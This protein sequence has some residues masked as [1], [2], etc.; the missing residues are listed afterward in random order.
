MEESQAPA[1]DIFAKSAGP[2]EESE[3]HWYSPFS[4]PSLLRIDPLRAGQSP[5][6]A[7]EVGPP[8][9]LPEGF[10]P[11][12]ADQD[13]LGPADDGRSGAAGFVLPSPNAEEAGRESPSDDEATNVEALLTLPAGFWAEGG[14][15][16]SGEELRLDPQAPLPAERLVDGPGDP[17]MVPV[18]APPIVLTP[19]LDQPSTSPE[20]VHPL[21]A[22]P[23]AWPATAADGPRRWRPAPRQRV[24]AL[25][26]G[27]AA[28]VIA[29]VMVVVGG[30]PDGGAPKQVETAMPLPTL[31]PSPTTTAPPSD[32]VPAPVVE[33]AVVSATVP[34][35]DPVGGAGP[36]KAP[37]GI[38]AASSPSTGGPA[39]PSAAAR[40]PAPAP[41]PAPARPAPAPARPAPTRP[42]PA[43]PPASAPT[44]VDP[45]PAPTPTSSIP[46]PRRDRTVP[47][48]PTVTTAAP[49]PTSTTSSLPGRACLEGVPPRP[50]VCK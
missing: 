17:A 46:T 40:K 5:E 42:A 34:S 8:L 36:L 32:T 37:A 39:S 21:V 4:D 2:L 6:P 11:G 12:G 24:A 25:T 20:E 48:E 22:A 9:S 1:D 27:A 23:T 28:V 50:V 10:W 3:D 31:F 19:V 14:S 47:T 16:L 29:A 44:N 26:A 43:P 35:I 30:G 41:A 38:A 49:R 13:P 45:A 15:D 33:P 18:D 7:D